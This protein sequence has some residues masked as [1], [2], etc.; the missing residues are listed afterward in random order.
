MQQERLV[1]LFE[2]TTYSVVN[3]FD[4]TLRPQ[5]TLTG[6]VE[7]HIFFIQCSCI[8]RLSDKLQPFADI[9]M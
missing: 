7:V 5:A 2:R 1:N 4:V 8:F 3:I 6:F 9:A